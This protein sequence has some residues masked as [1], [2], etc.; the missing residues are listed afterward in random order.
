[1]AAGATGAPN[2]A[3]MATGIQTRPRTFG[4]RKHRRNASGFEL[5]APDPNWRLAKVTFWIALI[6]R[7]TVALF[8]SHTGD[9][10]LIELI[11]APLFA[12]FVAATVVLVKG[13][14]FGW[15]HDWLVWPFA[16]GA[17]LVGAVIFVT[18]VRGG[19]SVFQA[20][21]PAL[22]IALIGGLW[23]ALAIIF[24]GVTPHWLRDFARKFKNAGQPETDFLPQRQASEDRKAAQNAAFPRDAFTL[25]P[26]RPPD[27]SA[28]TDRPRSSE[29]P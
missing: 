13:I 14:F 6:A 25:P 8:G 9:G 23:I 27:T 29:T 19:A 10:L 11:F 3:E 26:A 12:L 2:S 7:A 28:Y 16:C 5:K 22:V 20:I 17:L 21:G 1:M 15:D 24:L 18:L 4:G